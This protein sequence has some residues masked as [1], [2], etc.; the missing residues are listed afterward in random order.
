MDGASRTLAVSYRVGGI[1]G[2]APAHIPAGKD[3]G[4]VGGHIFICANQ[5]GGGDVKTFQARERWY[6]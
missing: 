6:G 1:P 5:S 2:E 4:K 3:A